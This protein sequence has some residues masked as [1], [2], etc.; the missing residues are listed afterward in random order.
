MVSR[1]GWATSVAKSLA[2][3]RIAGA[4][5]GCRCISAKHSVTEVGTG[6]VTGQSQTWKF[7]AKCFDALQ[8]FEMAYRILRHRRSPFV[9]AREKGFGAECDDLLQLAADD[10]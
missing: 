9:D 4:L 3:S 7:L 10:L 1:S 2:M 6:A 5:A 8:A